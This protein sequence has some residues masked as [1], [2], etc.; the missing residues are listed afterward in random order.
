[1]PSEEHQ[2]FSMERM[3][4]YVV[5]LGLVQERLKCVNPESINVI[6]S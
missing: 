2:T 3:V 1:M 4:C 5:L 6:Y